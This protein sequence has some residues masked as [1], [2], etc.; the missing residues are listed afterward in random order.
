[1]VGV[2]ARW[3]RSLQA[4][5]PGPC[6]E[7]RDRK[8]CLSPV[9][10]LQSISAYCSHDHSGRA[11][12]QTAPHPS[13]RHQSLQPH[14]LPPPSPSLTEGIYGRCFCAGGGGACGGWGSRLQRGFD[15]PSRRR[16]PA[17][18]APR[19]SPPLRLLRPTA[20]RLRVCRSRRRPR[21]RRRRWR[22]RRRASW[23][24]GGVGVRGVTAATTAV[25]A[26][27]VFW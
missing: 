17:R 25:A 1:M 21:C 7:V 9:P 24:G 11:Q 5:K 3:V 8:A 13:K 6:A 20:A 27:A 22:R 10:C 15:H 14:P 4:D 19:R 23:W 16:R 12:G 2:R 26:R 18:S